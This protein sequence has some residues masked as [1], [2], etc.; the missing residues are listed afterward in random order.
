[1]RNTHCIP[2]LCRSES[3]KIEVETKLRDAGPHAYLHFIYFAWMNCIVSPDTSKNIVSWVP[4]ASWQFFT[5]SM[6]LTVDV[7]KL[8]PGMKGSELIK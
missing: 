3:G 5:L 2:S 8:I 1:M 7:L 4:W 6:K